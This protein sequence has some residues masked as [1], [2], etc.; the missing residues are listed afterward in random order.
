MYGVRKI[1]FW[2]TKA[3]TGKKGFKKESDVFPLDI[4]KEIR[5][6]KIKGMKPVVITRTELKKDA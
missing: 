4:D 1:C 3:V 5:R 6:A 2:A